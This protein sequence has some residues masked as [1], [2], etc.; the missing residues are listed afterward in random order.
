M[1]AFFFRHIARYNAYVLVYLILQTLFTKLSN[2][3][4]PNPSISIE[5]FRS[6]TSPSRPQ[7]ITRSFYNL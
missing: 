7:R 4:N 3:G 5:T 2:G 6:S 1:L